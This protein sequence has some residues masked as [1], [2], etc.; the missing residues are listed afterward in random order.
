MLV[1]INLKRVKSLVDVKE[2][3]DLDIG[4]ETYAKI[5]HKKSSGSWTR[6]NDPVINSHLLYQLS[7]AGTINKIHIRGSDCPRQVSRQ[8]KCENI[9]L[10]LA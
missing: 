5:M 6:T 8:K 10:I 7:Y 3:C 9:F 2:K 1:N 4:G